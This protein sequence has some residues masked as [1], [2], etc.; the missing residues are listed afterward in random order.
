M[1]KW[2]RQLGARK[3]VANGKSRLLALPAGRQ[4]V[5]GKYDAAQTTHENR[6][7]WAN[8]DHLSAN[9]AMSPEVRRTL[10][11]RARYEVANNSYAKGIV[12]TLANYVVGTG[13]RLQMLTDDPEANRVIEQEFAK[14]SKAIG[15]AH[16][17]RTMR[18]A[19]CETGEVF[20]ILATNPRID[21]PVQLDLR[22]I[23]ADQVASPWPMPRPDANVVDGIVFDGFGNP[24]A[25]YVLRHHPGDTNAMKAGRVEYDVLPVESVIHLFRAER[26][27]QGRGI[28]EITPALPLFAMLRR[29]TLAVLG[30][31]E[32]AALPS[33]VIYTDAPA[34]SEASEVE[35]LDTVEMDRG[36][37]M[38][39]PFG[40]KIGQVRAEQPTT[41]YGEFKH[42]IINEIA[43]CLNMPFNIAAG[44]S[45][46]YNYASGR[47]DHQAFFKAIRIDQNFL[48]DVVLDR[49][50][51]AWI[52]E[53]VLIEGLLPQSVRTLD[54]EFPHQWFWDGF[55]HVDPAKEAN[56]QSTRLA[57]HTTTLAAE[58]AKAGE[59][60]ETALRQRAREVALMRELGLEESGV[61]SPESG[62]AA[63]EDNGNDVTEDADATAQAATW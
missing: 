27:G 47:L 51:K 29:Y 26:P 3:S 15:L 30:S 33:G 35:P 17:L 14:W 57:S 9:A 11:A 5:R 21:A 37:W 4:V 56:A 59:D 42:E 45:A 31:A 32:Q 41:V 28:P 36:T 62:G 10:R 24:V 55:E 43:R 44:N 58:Y 39:M 6:R 2:L 19:Q 25:Y 46:G 40:W 63:E 20:G 49:I 53:A 13:P 50:L 34:D 22:L 7:H 38:T 60:W 16:K 61:R 18:I 48:G 8:A 1:L 23:E 12:L 54:A 52:D